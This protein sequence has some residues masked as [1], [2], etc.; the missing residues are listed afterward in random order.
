[1]N[2]LIRAF[3]KPVCVLLYGVF[4]ALAAKRKPIP[5]LVLFATHAAEYVLIGRKIAQ[6]KGIAPAEGWPSASPSA[7][8]G[9]CPC[10]R[11][12]KHERKNRKLLS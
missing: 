11:A 12:E 1:M 10:A 4:A 7:S 9:G 3:G 2:K 6:D 8:P 5:L